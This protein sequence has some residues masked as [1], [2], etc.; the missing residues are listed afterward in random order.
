MDELGRYLNN[1]MGWAMLI[2][3]H[4]MAKDFVEKV[5]EAERQKLT[6]TLGHEPDSGNW[7]YYRDLQ[8]QKANQEKAR[9]RE[10]DREKLR[11]LVFGEEEV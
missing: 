4:D 2:T 5:M 10:T 1:M 6:E 3:A 9:Q 11:R 7:Q 8:W